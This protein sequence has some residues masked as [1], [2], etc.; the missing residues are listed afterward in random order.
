MGRVNQYIL[1]KEGVGMILKGKTRISCF[2]RSGISIVEQPYIMSYHS[3]IIL[4][5]NSGQ[6]WRSNRMMTDDTSMSRTCADYTF[7]KEGALMYFYIDQFGETI[8][9]TII[10]IHT[11]IGLLGDGF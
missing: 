2:A 5:L 4:A 10:E 1:E 9:D 11:E 7:P 8:K 3:D 6:Y